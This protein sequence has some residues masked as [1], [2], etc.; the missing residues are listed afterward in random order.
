MAGFKDPERFHDYARYKIDCKVLDAFFRLLRAVYYPTM[1]TPWDYPSVHG[2]KTENA[3]R[4]HLEDDINP[5]V[6]YYRDVLIPELAEAKPDVVGISMVY[7]TQSVQ[8]GGYASDLSIKKF[9]T[10]FLSSLAVAQIIA[11]AHLPIVRYDSRKP[12]LA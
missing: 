11:F 2:L 6:S 7:A 5:F 9:T 3:V 10:R 8:D 12:Q 1:V 4:L